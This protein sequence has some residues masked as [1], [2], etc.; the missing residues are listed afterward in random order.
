MKILDNI[1]YISSLDKQN[2]AGSIASL[3]KQIKQ[4]WSEVS[5]INI[6]WRQNKDIDNIV[7]CGMGGSNLPAD[8]LRNVFYEDIKIPFIMIND[9]YL[10]GFVNKRSLVITVSY[11]GNTEETISCLKEAIKRKAKIFIISVGGKLQETATEHCLKYYGYFFKP[12]Y[13]PCNQPRI[14]SG[15]LLTAELWILKNICGFKFINDNE[16]NKIIKFIDN[17]NR[18]FC[19]EQKFKNNSAKII[20]EQLKGNIPVIISSEFLSGNGHIITNQINENAKNFAIYFNIP[21]LNHHLLE[22]LIFPDINHKSLKFLFIG[23]EFYTEKN[24]NRFEITKDVLKKNNIKF[25]EY[26]CKKKY[27]NSKQ[28]NYL[29]N[30]LEILCLGSYVSFYLGILN[31]LD[32][33]PIPWVDY[34]KEKL[35]KVK[36]DI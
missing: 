32:P 34:F 35:K 2:M 30:S 4:T 5:K 1:E 13:N 26:N 28:L 19:V 18:N 9:Y 21:E 17:T 24:K 14:G 16:I 6:P 15:Y 7:F 8:L 22:S 25:I 20:A 29:F 10:P 23:S 12:L 27:N 11:S 3:S 36:S 33:S 31:N